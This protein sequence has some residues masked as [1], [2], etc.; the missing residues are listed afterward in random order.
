ML[1]RVMSKLMDRLAWTMEISFLRVYAATKRLKQNLRKK[2]QHIFHTL[3]LYINGMP[4]SPTQRTLGELRKRGYIPEIVERW[5][6]WSK[7][8]HDLFGFI[9]VL[10]IH[11]EEHHMIAVQATSKTNRSARRAKILEHVN[12]RMW[13]QAGGT[14]ELWCWGK[15]KNSRYWDLVVD[16]FYVD[17][18]SGEVWSEESVDL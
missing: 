16:Q 5:N 9:D 2:K 8:R 7:T 15:P 10:A 3:K 11:P 12:T 17:K 4:K 13:L 18:V 6:P 14:L 1:R